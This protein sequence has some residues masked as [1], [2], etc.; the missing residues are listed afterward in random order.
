MKFARLILSA[1]IVLGAHL[2]PAQTYVNDSW[3]DG[4]RN[5]P[6]SPTYSEYGIDGD[7]DLNL[8]SV[9]YG[10]SSSLSSSVGHLIG[11]TA[12]TSRQWL[13]HFT[14][15][16]PLSLAN[17]GDSI[18]I[19]LNFTPTTILANANRNMRFGLFNYSAGTRLTTDATPGGANVTGYS[20]FI[21]FAPTFGT[22]NPLQVSERTNPS[23]TD[24]QGTTGDFTLLGSGGANGGTGFTSG[25]AYR[26]EFIVTRLGA[27]TVSNSV[28]FFDSLNAVLVTASGVDATGVLGFD[29]FAMRPANTTSTA[30]TFDF[31]QFKV[32]YFGAVPEPTTLS[33]T[34]IALAIWACRRRKLA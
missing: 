34:G 27:T 4:T 5:D 33:L 14:P 9:W 22:S 12:A 17:I 24:L 2:A 16:S 19:T 30:A 31:T 10:N 7:L 1:S 32:E 6:A 21:N 25:A 26:L 11:T 3:L 23:S 28:T 18:K 13:T 8:E 20:A 15:S 29:T